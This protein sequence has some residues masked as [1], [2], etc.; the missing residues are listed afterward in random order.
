MMDRRNI[1]ALAGA[2][3]ASPAGASETS[4]HPPP[5][6]PDQASFSLPISA[7]QAVLDGVVAAANARDIEGL[8]AKLNYPHVRFSSGTV[9]I[10]TPGDR[11]IDLYIMGPAAEWHH[12]AWL[13]RTVLHAG[14]T[15][16]HLDVMLGRYRKD[17]TFL[18]A[19]EALYIVTLQDGHWGLQGDSSYAP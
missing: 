2:A 19:Y 6:R 7:A 5:L 14:P 1:M 8:R 10:L 4:V 9:A 18:G 11:K 16:V 17:D 3:L 12:S 15:K 13:R